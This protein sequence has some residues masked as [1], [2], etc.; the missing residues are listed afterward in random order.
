MEES[1]SQ[2]PTSPPDRLNEIGVLKRREI[3]ARILAPLLEDLGREFGRERVL[4]VARE[5]IIRIAR[6]QGD[7]LAQAVGGRTLEKFAGALALWKKDD[8]LQIAVLEQS[9]QR[10]S[11]NVTRCRY[12]ELYRGLGIS[13]LGAVLSCNRDFS[14]IEGFNS[15]VTLT[16]TQTI[17]EG[18]PFCDFRFTRKGEG[19]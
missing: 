7:Q 15:Q 13:E 11:F 8:A 10:F 19:E 2:P 14:L 3:E 4:A 6:E 18:A 9:D 5:T 17:M 16:R 12:A 1:R